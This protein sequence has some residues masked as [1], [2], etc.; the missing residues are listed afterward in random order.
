MPTG[1][2]DERALLGGHKTFAIRSPIET[3]RLNKFVSIPFGVVHRTLRIPILGLTT[4]Y[5]WPDRTFLMDSAFRIQVEQF[6]AP[7]ARSSH[8]VLCQSRAQQWQQPNASIPGAK[9][10]SFNN[11]RVS[12]ILIR[13]WSQHARKSLNSKD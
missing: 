12:P 7:R 10:L 2:K 1:G 8:L 5:S 4:K 6:A 13:I 9:F 11:L 3:I